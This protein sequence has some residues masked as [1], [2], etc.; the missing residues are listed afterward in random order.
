M[1]II[2]F[3]K[4]DSGPYPEP[5]KSSSHSSNPFSKPNFNINVFI[6]A[7]SRIDAGS[8]PDELNEFFQFI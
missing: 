5:D 3:G 7:T 2:V 4:H 6:R 8:K 1:F